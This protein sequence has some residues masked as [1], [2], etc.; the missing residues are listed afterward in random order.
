MLSDNF[1]ERYV[2]L[3]KDIEG[4]KEDTKNLQKLIQEKKEEDTTEL[5]TELSKNKIDNYFIEKQ[6]K[7]ENDLC[8]PIME[9]HE[10]VVKELN[11]T[12]TEQSEKLQEKLQEID[13]LGE[14]L[15]KARASFNDLCTPNNGRT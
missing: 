11:D 9:E 13:E 4:I 6:E 14:E 8:T 3:E 15:G 2:G 1:L 12:L 7:F 5:S 10:R